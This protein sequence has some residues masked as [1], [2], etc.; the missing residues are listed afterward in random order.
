MILGSPERLEIVPNVDA[1]ETSLL[2]SPKF[3]LL[4]KL[5]ASQRTDA[6]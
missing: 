3:V 4:N 6:A 5:N 1:P 2:G